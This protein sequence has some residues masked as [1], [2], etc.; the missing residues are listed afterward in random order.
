MNK[1]FALLKLIPRSIYLALAFLMPVFFLPFTSEFYEFN[2]W[3]LLFVA[4]VI[5][6]ITAGVNVVLT[7]K[8]SISKSPVDLS[9][10]LLTTIIILSTVFSINKPSSIFGSYGR[11]FPSLMGF[12]TILFYYYIATPNLDSDD[13]IAKVLYT[14]L[15]GSTVAT[16]VSLLS[17]FKVY[18]GDAAYF[19]STNFTLTGSITTSAG[20]AALTAVLSLALLIHA[21]SVV[22]K[23]LLTLAILL[24]LL[25]AVLVGITLGWVILVVGTILILLSTP[26]QKLQHNKF[27][28]LIIAGGALALVFVLVYPSTR[29]VIVNKDY[30]REVV[31]SVQES[32]ISASS[33][34]RDF[35]I[36]GSGPST[37]Y[38]NFPRYKSVLFNSTDAWNIRFDKPYDEIFNILGTMG[39]IGMLAAAYFGSKVAKFAFTMRKETEDNGEIVALRAG[40][41]LSLLLFFFTYATV[42]NVF[43]FFMFLSLLVAKLNL[44]N[45][46][47]VED[48][49]TSLSALSLS[50]SGYVDP[51]GNKTNYTPVIIFVPLVIALVISALAGYQFYKVYAAEY[52]TRLGIEATQAN[53]GGA[54][55]RYQAQAINL[56]PQ[57][58]AYDTVYAQTNLAVANAIAG[59]QNL[60][61]QDKQNIQA[62]ISE[63]IRSIRVATEVLNPL[64]VNDWEV[65]AGIYRSLIGVAD[66][67]DQW[68]LSSYNTA[69]QLDPTNP[70]LRVNLGGIYYLTKDYLSAAN[71]FRQATILKNDYANGY[72]NLAQALALLKDYTNAQAAL[73]IVQRLVPADSPDAQQVVKDLA[74][75][76]QMAKAAATPATNNKPTIEQLSQPTTSTTQDKL[77]QPGQAPVKP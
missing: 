60:S 30:P 52:Y 1:N 77:T 50:S 66:N 8:F 22:K 73:Q 36:L 53:N 39:I 58:D 27:D 5:L 47:N 23:S 20:L 65:R 38:L 14:F 61:D 29:T 42:L 46:S 71:Q 64:N 12:L 11:W 15:A 3:A 49:M 62:L 69:I 31:L 7:R 35:P 2:K 13:I 16:L 68:A 70:R 75:L 56:N 33:A 55:L 76:D 48:V 72:Y 41:L 21:N 74:T 6:L 37:F 34:I 19:K 32:W 9:L 40:L 59:N 4:T 63:S 54:A 25:F 43:V 45:T 44:R 51:N 26:A 10:L 57:V 17:Y 67:A 18:I 24:N 28:L